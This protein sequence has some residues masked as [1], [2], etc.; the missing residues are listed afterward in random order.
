[1]GNVAIGAKLLEMHKRSMSTFAELGNLQSQKMQNTINKTE[2]VVTQRADTNIYKGWTMAGVTASSFAFSLLSVPF[3]DMKN[4]FDAAGNFFPHFAKPVEAQFESQMMPMHMK[5][6]L[7]T[8][9]LL[10]EAQQNKGKTREAQKEEL[11][12]I[13]EIL[14]EQNRA[15]QAAKLR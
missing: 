6:M 4:V 3:P 13:Q 12:N 5:E 7:N 8:Q 1:M 10:P 9:T 2:Q 15:A 11:Q 14:R